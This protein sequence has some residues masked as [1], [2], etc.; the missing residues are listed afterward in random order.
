MIQ[1]PPISSFL[2]SYLWAACRPNF[3]HIIRSGSL[4]IATPGS[5]PHLK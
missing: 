2:H 5:N 1:I 4:D 3:K